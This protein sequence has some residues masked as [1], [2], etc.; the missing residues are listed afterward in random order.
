MLSPLTSSILLIMLFV[1]SP[2]STALLGK[3]TLSAE[4]ANVDEKV[5]FAV[6]LKNLSTKHLCDFQLVYVEPPEYLIEQA[7]WLENDKVQCQSVSG[8]SATLMKVIDAGQDFTL[9]G[10]LRPTKGHSKGKPTAIFS[11]TGEDGSSSNLGITFGDFVAREWYERLGVRFYS[12]IKDFALPIVLVALGLLYQSWDKKREN[13]RQRED[14]ERAQTLQTWNSMLPTSHRY[15]TRHYMPVAAAADGVL[16]SLKNYRKALSDKEKSKADQWSERGFYSMG[17][18]GRRLRHLG[19]SIG[20]FYFK[21]RVGEELAKHSVNG[22]RGL[23]Y[24][25]DSLRLKNFSLLLDNIDPNETYGTFEQKRSEPAT[26]PIFNAAF[27]DFV[28]W[29]HSGKNYKTS[30]RNLRAFL[31]VLQ[32]EMNCPYEFWYGKGE[33]LNIDRYTL[34]LVKKTISSISSEPDKA[35]FASLAEAYLKRACS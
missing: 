12:F 30:V 20:G 34:N 17:L 21:D 33:R 23:Y 16:D 13:R 3:G 32:Y 27:D 24:W 9:W 4:T 18:L 22:F 26:S 28:T 2:Q 15:A 10:I 29:L 19:E 11:W 25:A 14:Q 5:N 1:P 8:N 6:V 7:C 31:A 35:G